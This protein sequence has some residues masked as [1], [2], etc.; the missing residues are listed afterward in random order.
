M[1]FSLFPRSIHLPLFTSSIR[2]FGWHMRLLSL[3]IVYILRSMLGCLLTDTL[4]SFRIWSHNLFIFLQFNPKHPFTAMLRCLI[5]EVAD[6]SLDKLERSLY[7][8]TKRSYWSPSSFSGNDLRGSS[9]LLVRVYFSCLWDA[10]AQEG[11]NIA[12]LRSSAR[13]S[14]SFLLKMILCAYYAVF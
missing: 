12:K 2:F 9:P 10:V 6:F 1:F 3:H 13:D 7:S 5:I 4:L 11:G 14:P 8:M